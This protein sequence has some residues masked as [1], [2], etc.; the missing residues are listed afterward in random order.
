[1]AV[2]FGSGLVDVGGLWTR[3][4]KQEDLSVTVLR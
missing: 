2:G 1:M 3:R 4:E